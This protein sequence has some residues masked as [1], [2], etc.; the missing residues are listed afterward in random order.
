MRPFE[1]YTKEENGISSLLYLEQNALIG[2]ELRGLGV[3][4][5]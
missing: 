4:Q 5:R 1:K 3:A 2:A